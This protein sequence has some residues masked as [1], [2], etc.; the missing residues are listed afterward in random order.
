MPTLVDVMDAVN[1]QRAELAIVKAIVTRSELSTHQG[2]EE[3][4][5]LTNAVAQHVVGKMHLHLWKG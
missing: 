4:S 2:L 3:V 5:G 1:Q